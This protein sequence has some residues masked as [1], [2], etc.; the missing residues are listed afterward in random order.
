MSGIAV[1]EK[2]KQRV[3]SDWKPVIDLI[4]G[5]RV[6]EFKNV[7]SDHSYVSEYFR[8]DWSFCERPI[9]HIVHVNLNPGALTAWHM[10][11]T[12]WDNIVCPSGMIKLVLC[13]GRKES[14]TYRMVNEFNMSPLRPIVVGFPPGVWHGFQNLMS[15]E[16]SSFMN[17]SDAAYD[18]ENPDEWRLPLDTP[19]IPYKF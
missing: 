17:M 16:R 2:E 18:Y 9:A 6:R 11:K 13:D 15:S 19:E 5:V 1:P 8:D 7:T 12:K 3:T 10:H 4:D 14:S